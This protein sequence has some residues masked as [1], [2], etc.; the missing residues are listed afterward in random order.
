MKKEDPVIGSVNIKVY[1]DEIAERLW[2]K[3]AAVMVGAGFSKN[4]NNKFPD[5]PQLG[6][7]FYE[8]IHGRKPENQKYLNVLKLADEVEAAFGRATLNQLLRSNIPDEEC[9]PSPLHV[10]FLELPWTDVFTTNYDTLLERACSEVTLHKYDVVVNK[11]DLVFSEKP[12]IVK[13]HGSFPSERPFIITEEDYR[14]YPKDFAPFVNTVQQALL[15]NT[16][17]LIG[18]SGDDPNFL[19]W[20]GWIRDNICNQN[21]PKIYLIGI[22]NLSD[23]RIKLFAQRNI[24]LVDLSEY[25]E[26]GRDHYKALNKFVNY[27]QSR[28]AEDNR[29]GW[30]KAGISLYR[31]GKLRETPK[32]EK[33]NKLLTVWKQEHQT[34]PGWWILPEDRRNHIWESTKSWMNFI[35]P[36]DTLPAP[37]DIDFAYELVW[38]MEK[39]LCPLSK[40]QTELVEFVLKKYKPFSGKGD[41]TN[42]QFLMPE[43]LKW[44]ELD[45]QMI[46]KTWLSLSLSILRFYREEGLIA[47]WETRDRE[48]EGVEQYLSPDQSANLHYE[49]VLHAVFALDLPEIEKQLKDWPDNESLP[50]WEVK[51]A[52]VLA[53]I[54]RIEQAE[55]ILEQSLKNIRSQL[56]LKPITTDYSLVSQEAFT[57]LLFQYVGLSALSKKGEWSEIQEFK[58]QF[59]ERWNA[60]KQYKCDPW[61]ELKL[62]EVCLE[63]P[64]VERQEHVEKRGFDI[65]RI[66]ETYHFGE[67]DEA[68]SAYAFLR[69]CEEVGIPFRM[70]NVVLG[71]KSAEGTLSRITKYSPFWALATMVRI[72][73]SKVVDQI[74]NRESMNNFDVAYVDSLVERYLESITQCQDE[75]G[76]GSAK[77]ADN[78]GTLL[79]KVVPEILSRLCCKCSFEYKG[80]MLDFLLD[81]YRSDQKEKYCGIGNLTKRLLETIPY[82]NQFALIPKL[83]EFPVLEN[84]G[85]R[86]K[87]EFLPPLLFL[88]FEKELAEN[89]DKPIIEGDR[90]ENLLNK[91][92]SQDSDV[93]EWAAFSIGRLYR[94]GL[95]EEGWT[96]KFAKILWSQRDKWN[97][98]A[99]P[100]SRYKSYFLDLPHPEGI[101]P[102]LLFKKYLQ[103]AQLPLQKNRG[104]SS[105]QIMGGN[106]PFC[107]EI[108][109]ASRLIKWTE[110]EA[111]DIFKRLMEWWDA[112]KENLKR[113]EKPLPL[114]PIAEEFKNRFLRLVDVLVEVIA[115]SFSQETET[116]TKRELR[117]LLDEL[118]IYGL[119]SL[120]AEAACIHVFPDNKDKIITKIGFALISS[121]GI[122]L[123]D[124]LRA[125]EVVALRSN[126]QLDEKGVLYLLN[127]V[128][129]IVW[130]RK[131]IGLT[132]ALTIIANIV[133]K[134]PECF[135]GDL[136]KH[137]LLGL[138][139]IAQDTGLFSELTDLDFSKKLEIRRAAAGL[140][141]VLFEHYSQ[142]GGSI[143]DAIN[144]WKDICHSDKEFAEIRNQWVQM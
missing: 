33:I 47:K 91:A 110:R 128:G 124:G 101:A 10:K 115:P 34:Y 15:E 103:N 78:F 7:L 50:F 99:Y 64:P 35:S 83:L 121:N 130:W 74:F 59:S 111:D 53:E 8:K 68:F 36:K 19:Q 92:N 126:T 71:K 17:C 40:D 73:D 96:E 141:Y 4:A 25:P 94:L 129:E 89:W 57:M 60:L 102:F 84:L 81:V 28:K 65:G 123:V 87:K 21:S 82:R 135:S 109:Y 32:K 77:R 90:I 118:Q 16:L 54:G 122:S 43:N 31:G 56:N 13:L 119:P 46:R 6:D 125:I 22:F 2:S 107:D 134:Q 12:R 85:L 44:K 24:V 66:T 100:S 29:L 72:G 93:R 23:A 108:L 1:L 62:F 61:N 55:K 98:P 26:V 5:W 112:D 131:A 37:T 75:M 117:R 132:G 18:F 38:R 142:H 39:C 76:S 51:R 11:E 113:D 67:D 106:I 136:E 49:R 45:W 95:L 48:I 41:T 86:I 3:H 80:K 30:P 20:I 9:K 139:N 144:T 58:Q 120:R 105:I 70:P 14:R 27:L 133:K 127:M 88:G 97:L 114:G 143:P 69:F 104:V 138:Q 116:S 140:A 63:K 79:A 42:P 52:G 137:V